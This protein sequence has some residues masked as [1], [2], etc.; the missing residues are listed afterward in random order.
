MPEPSKDYVVARSSTTRVVLQTSEVSHDP[1]RPDKIE[2]RFDRRA[3]DRPIAITV[4]AADGL[5]PSDLRRL[6]WNSWFWLADVAHREATPDGEGLIE[7]IDVAVAFADPQAPPPAPRRPGRRG[8]SHE[9]YQQTAQRYTQLLASG[10]RNPTAT[11]AQERVV[12]RD[13]AAGWVSGARKRGF[14]PPARP[15]RAG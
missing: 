14:L 12:S 2:I 7:V 3:P 1:N 10:V 15:G 13:T 8:H 4:T 6:P 11:L 5:R 9:H